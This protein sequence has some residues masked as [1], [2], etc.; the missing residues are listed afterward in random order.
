MAFTLCIW[1]HRRIDD[2]KRKTPPRTTP[3]Q[4]KVVANWQMCVEIERERK[5]IKAKLTK[6]KRIV[7]LLINILWVCVCM[8]AFGVRVWVSGFS[9]IHSVYSNKVDFFFNVKQQKAH[10]MLSFISLK[11]IWLFIM[12]LNPFNLNVECWMLNVRL[13]C[14][15]LF[16]HMF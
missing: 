7:K 15:E 4:T 16:L 11:P 1:N 12:N 2:T 14:F 13:W 8:C 10:A 5:I 9:S 6:R 3:K